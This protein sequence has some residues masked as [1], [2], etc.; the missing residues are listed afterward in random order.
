L[1]SC[2]VFLLLGC[3]FCRAIFF[4]SLGKHHSLLVD[5]LWRKWE[6]GILTCFARQFL[7]IVFVWVLDEFDFVCNSNPWKL[8]MFLKMWAFLVS[9]ESSFSKSSDYADVCIASSFCSCTIEAGRFASISRSDLRK[10]QASKWNRTPKKLVRTKQASHSNKM[11]CI[12]QAAATT[13]NC[14]PTCSTA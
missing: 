5:E 12:L 9:L 10:I 3:A 7:W 11:D 6:K 1:H 4:P 8:I 2:F 14:S 13:T